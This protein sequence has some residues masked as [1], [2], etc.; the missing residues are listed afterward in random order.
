MSVSIG[1]YGEERAALYLEEQGVR[2]LARNYRTRRGELDL[3]A[4]DGEII[5]FVEVRFRAESSFGSPLETVGPKK[6]KRIAYAAT[7]YLAKHSHF[8]RRFPCRFDVISIERVPNR[9]IWIKNA[10]D[11]CFR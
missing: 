4:Q 3:I 5:C 11:Q 6:Q 7:E 1:Q 10:F 8:A 9:I 2:I